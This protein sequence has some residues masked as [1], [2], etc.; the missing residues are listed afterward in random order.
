M[1]ESHAIVLKFCFVVCDLKGDL[2][3]K[4]ALHFGVSRETAHLALEET[5]RIPANAKRLLASLPKLP[6]RNVPLLPKEEGSICYFSRL[7][8][9]KELPIN[10]REHTVE[11]Y[12]TL[13]AQFCLSK[14]ESVV[15]SRVNGRSFITG[16]FS[17]PNLKKLFQ[18][19]AAVLTMSSLFCI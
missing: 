3:D 16:N 8:G 15:S 12:E 17:L 4:L 10:K 11:S 6:A 5:S 13:Q 2:T 9:F 1:H 19:N 18:R 7:F 14:S